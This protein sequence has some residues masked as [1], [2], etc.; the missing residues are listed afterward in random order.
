MLTARKEPVF[1]YD[2]PAPYIKEQKWFPLKEPFNLYMDKFRDRKQVNK[3]YLMKKL[4]KTHPFKG[5]EQELQFPNA[6]SI[7][8]KVNTAFLKEV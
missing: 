5:P 4:A 3:E 7:D 8:K 1:E 6:H 2:F